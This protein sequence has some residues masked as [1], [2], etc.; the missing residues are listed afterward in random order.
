MHLLLTLFLSPSHVFTDNSWT[1][2]TNKRFALK[3]LSGS[4][5]GLPG[6]ASGK[7]PTCQCRRY[8]RLR[9]D[10]W[11]G[12]I[13]WR[14]KWQ[15]TPVFLPREFYGQRRL[16]GYS[17]WGRKQSD[18]TERLSLSKGNYPVGH[19]KDLMYS[20]EDLVDPLT[21]TGKLSIPGKMLC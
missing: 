20:L 6:G 2:L 4:A 7:E 1:L 18:M 8:K 19:I 15:P 11:V 3:F 16:T 17:L 13:P 9:F 12:E 21:T 5:W 10:P 14:R